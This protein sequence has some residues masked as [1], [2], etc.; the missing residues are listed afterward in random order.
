METGLP[1]RLLSH[2]VEP[3]PLSFAFFY[4]GFLIRELEEKLLHKDVQ[5]P[6]E[7]AYGESSPSE[8]LQCW[9]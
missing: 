9:W 2:S 4:L 7:A 6:S 5:R 1:I 8:R 3:E